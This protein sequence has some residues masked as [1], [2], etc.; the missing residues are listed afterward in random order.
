VKALSLGRGLGEGGREINFPPFLQDGE[1]AR[2]VSEAGIKRIEPERGGI[3]RVFAGSEPERV[4]SEALWSKRR[5][6]KWFD[7]SSR[8]FS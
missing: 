5:L 6:L 2:V 7:L 1:S 8:R 3:Q 4:V